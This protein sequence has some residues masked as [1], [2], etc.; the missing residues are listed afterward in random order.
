MTI[1]KFVDDFKSKNISNSKVAQN[2]VSDYLKKT[3]D[4]KVYLPFRTKRA[5]VEMVVAQNIE[6]VDGVK[7]NDS[8]NQYIGFVVAMI[9]AHTNLEFGDDPVADYD[10]LAENNLLP[11]I[12]ATFQESYDECQALLNLCVQNELED[13]N[14]NVLIG[15][16]LNGILHRL[17]G[18]GEALKKEFGNTDIKKILGDTLNNDDLA[19]LKGFLDKYNK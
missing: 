1:Q 3:L 11:Q 13:N 16:F 10:L 19:N 12:I 5:I 9:G 2:A 7:K 17:D 18:V 6:W 4:I 15:K 14:V 8:I